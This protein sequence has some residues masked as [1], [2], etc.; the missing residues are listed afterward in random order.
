MEFRAIARNSIHR[1]RKG[2]A[3]QRPVFKRS[4]SSYKQR[5]QI[6]Y[7]VALLEFSPIL[8]YTLIETLDQ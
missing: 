5:N 7:E 2:S 1:K 6:W 3:W 8:G 4:E